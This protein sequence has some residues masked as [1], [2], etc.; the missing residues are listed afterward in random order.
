MAK[1][2]QLDGNNLG[3]GDR[4]GTTSHGGGSSGINT[5]SKEWNPEFWLKRKI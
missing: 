3:S 5:R 4:N 1:M 2:V